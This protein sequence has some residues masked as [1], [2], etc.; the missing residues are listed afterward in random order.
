MEIS[1]IVSG[2]KFQ[3]QCELI[4]GL[5]NDIAFNPLIRLMVN[6]GKIKFQDISELQKMP[7][8]SYNNPKY[9]FI[10]TFHIKH[11]NTAKLFQKFINKFVLLSHNCDDG[12]V[13]PE[14]INNIIS[15]DKLIHWW[16]S[17]LNIPEIENGK[18]SYIH[19]GIANSQWQHGNSNHFK[20]IFE[21]MNKLYRLDNTNYEIYKKNTIYFY[22][23][24]STNKD[25]RINCARILKAKGLPNTCSFDIPHEKYLLLLS[26]YKMAICPVGNGFD[27]HRLWECFYC[28]VVPIVLN[29]PMHQTINKYIPIIIL[30]KWDDFDMD[31]INEQYRQIM[32]SSAGDIY[33]DITKNKLLWFNY[34][35]TRIFNNK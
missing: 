21:N 19:I 33:R 34:W 17:N 22:F 32:Q 15:C 14:E 30:D 4:I 35:Q 12:I 28:G 20:I 13:S 29:I 3:L 2:E 7:D 8:A 26:T 9:I 5:K 11:F 24:V 1:N 6:E 23:N 10:Y 31:K 16:S 25:A 18:L 27:T